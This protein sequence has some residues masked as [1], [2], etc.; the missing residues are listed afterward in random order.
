MKLA[1]QVAIITGASEGIGQAIACNFV[2]EGARVV[3]GARSESKL[4]ALAASLGAERALAV[5][6][7]VADPQQVQRLVARTVERFGAIDILVNSAGIGLYGLIEETNWEHF[8]RM[9]EVNFFGAVRCTRAALPHLQERRGV[10][11]NISSVAGKLA[12]PYMSGYCATKFALNAYSTAL[13]MELARAGVH[14]VTICPGRVKTQFHRSAYRDGQNLPGIF[15]RRESS[16]IAPAVVARATLQAIQKRRREV[17]IPSRLRLA[18]AFRTLFP[19]FTDR[20]LQ[21]IVR[22]RTGEAPW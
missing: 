3:L 19:A 13:R 14:V 5:P 22:K 17:V 21:R 18:I 6:T 1:N 11:V 10:V 9:W 20:M 16:G 7:D 8:Q 15:R 2:D 12:L 4:R